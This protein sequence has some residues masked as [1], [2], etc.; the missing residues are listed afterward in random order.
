MKTNAKI[1]ISRM[2]KMGD[3][4]LSL[5]AIQAIKIANPNTEISILASKNNQELLKNI[6]YIDN[7]IFVNTEVSL[8]DFFKNLFFLRKKKI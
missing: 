3:M 8:I 4:I 2:D 7:Y 6:D 5:P 1:C